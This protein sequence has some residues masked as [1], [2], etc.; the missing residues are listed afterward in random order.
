MEANHK[1]INTIKSKTAPPRVYGLSK[2][3]PASQI[4]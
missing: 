3:F 4:F 1:H 2:S